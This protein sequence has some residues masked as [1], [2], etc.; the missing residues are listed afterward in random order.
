[1][2]N[3]CIFLGTSKK[4]KEVYG[5]KLLN[6]MSAE[7]GIDKNAAFTE[8]M[9]KENKETLKNA[10]FAFGTWGFPALSV[11]QIKE[12]LPNLKYVFYAA[13]SVKGFA[14]AY[15]E[16][17]IRIFSAAAANAVPVAQVTSAQITLANKGFFQHIMHTK[18]GKDSVARGEV[19]LY[20]GNIGAKIGIIGAGAIG[21]RV[22]ELL[23]AEENEIFVFDPFLSAETAEKLGVRLCSL[24]TLFSECDTISNHLANNE[25]TQGILNYGLFS[26]MKP[27]AVFINTGRGAQVVE[28]DLV[29]ALSEQPNRIAVLDVTDP[30]PPIPDHPFFKMPNVFLTPHFAGSCGNGPQRMARYMYEE[31]L[32]ITDGEKPLYEVTQNMLKTMA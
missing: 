2:N 3:S 10:A 23:S 21:R 5:E 15:F 18:S 30:E 12:Y 32:R 14:D 19:N 4:I 31:Y 24:E 7:I 13:G 29:K 22:I 20:P 9:L 6:R 8:D 11:S 28:Q 25:Q 16:N 27:N 1:M 26:R 17:G